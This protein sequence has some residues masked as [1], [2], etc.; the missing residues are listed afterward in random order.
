MGPFEELFGCP[1]MNQLSHHI[2]PPRLMAGTQT[3]SIVSVEA[4]AK[5]VVIAP[6]RIALEFLRTS[7]NHLLRF[8]QLSSLAEI[9]LSWLANPRVANGSLTVPQVGISDGGFGLV[10]SYLQPF[11]LCARRD[12]RNAP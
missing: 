5:Q 9:L 3:S 10:D 1:N 8:H 11:T 12:E 7:V 2:R 6:V 4:F